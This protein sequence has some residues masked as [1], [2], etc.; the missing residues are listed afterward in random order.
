MKK[1]LTVMTMTL[2]FILPTNV[3]ANEF[4]S[5]VNT[6][7]VPG[8]GINEGYTLPT[9]DQINAEAAKAAIAEAYTEAKRAPGLSLQA[10]GGSKTNLVGSYKQAQ[11]YTCGPAAARNAI[12]GYLSKNGLS[13]LPTEATLAS[14]LGTTT[15]GTGFDATLWQN[16]MNQYAPGNNYTLVW[17]TTSGWS[18]S[19]SAKV[20]YAID[21]TNNYDVIADLYHGATSTPINAAYASG[22]A[23]YV[24]IY[25]YNDSAQTYN[26]SDSNT[27][28]SQTLYT[29][30]YAKMANA[31]QQRG[32]IW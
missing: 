4:D 31:T 22:A 11:S 30:T 25:G 7:P 12:A 13:S 20:I 1:L 17:G 18:A 2:C 5:L 27:A 3:F 10:A 15:A 23:H 32:I 14:A 6:V 19:L 26:V 29:T 28:V 21:K 16:V 24:C 8:S 9:Q